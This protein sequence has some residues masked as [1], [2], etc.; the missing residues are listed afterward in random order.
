MELSQPSRRS[1]SRNCIFVVSNSMRLDAK[2][3]ASVE[4]TPVIC[5]ST[6]IDV[7]QRLH[8]S[9]TALSY[10]APNEKYKRH[11][12]ASLRDLPAAVDAWMAVLWWCLGLLST[13]TGR[14]NPGIFQHC[15]LLSRYQPA[16]RSAYAKKGRLRG[17]LSYSSINDAQAPN[18]V[19]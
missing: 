11:H 12:N 13:S 14:G 2:A 9:A 17:I 4:H 1:V 3:S 8:H 18:E 16:S 15:V 19:N 6:S 10:V 7:G 5:D